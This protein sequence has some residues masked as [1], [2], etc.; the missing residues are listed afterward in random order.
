MSMSLGGPFPS[1]ALR[2]AVD[3]ACDE[4]IILLAAAGNYWPW[5]VYPA[6]YDR[7]I[8]VAACD[9]RRRMWQWS[10]TGESVDVT[11][12]G[13]NVWV[14]RAAAGNPPIYE[15]GPGSGTSF[16]VATAAGVTALW[17]AFHG[18]E[19]L[20]SRYGKANLAGVFREL[21]VRDGV[22]TPPDW[23]SEKCGAGIVHARRLLEAALPPPGARAAP[24]ALRPL[25]A[26]WAHYF[27]DL[28]PAAVESALGEILRTRPA[29]LAPVLDRLGDEVV[30]L[31]ATEPALRDAVR[32]RA[33]GATPRGARA[34]GTPA[35]P[36]AVLRKASPTL[37]RQLRP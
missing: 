32:E 31:L 11:A 23:D 35:A 13:A 36:D 26:P 34:R 10:A 18:R 4:G 20:I 12:P 16:A 5:V 30:F 1:R 24:R 8:A 33:T 7:V 21:L 37:R 9:H 14:A 19:Q 27:P 15:V 3:A 22:Q 29:R 17:L 25:R 6:A 2:R 28:D